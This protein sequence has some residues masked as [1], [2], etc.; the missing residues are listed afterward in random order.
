[1]EGDFN[2]RDLLCACGSLCLLRYPR[3]DE[4]G[5]YE[6]CF[7]TV[8]SLIVA[9]SLWA[10]ELY[11]AI[12]FRGATA[13]V[14]N[15]LESALDV[16]STAIVLYRLFGADALHHNARNSILEARIST[17]LCFVMIVLAG[18]FIGFAAKTFYDH[19]FESNQEVLTE[20]WITMPSVVAYLIVG[21]VQLQLSWTLK[22]TSL[23]QDAMISIFGALAA[24]G[25]LVSGL[26]SISHWQTAEL[27]ATEA[28]EEKRQIRDV[29]NST[30]GD[31]DSLIE[32]KWS[33]WWLDPLMTLCVGLLL[34]TYG[35]WLLYL[36]SKEFAWWKQAFWFDP[37]PPRPAP[38]LGKADVSVK[39]KRESSPLTA[40]A[41]ETSYSA[42]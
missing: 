3:F 23:K 24:F 26:V 13:I 17:F 5:R 30:G 18:V 8:V 11:M 21:V 22:L 40:S 38:P 14:E 1:M 35:L 37:L 16:F 2:D 39:G 12:R 33:S 4:P 41:P 42:S 10:V 19:E 6:A 31:A 27:T 36:D 9:L 29:V 34:M 28:E 15:C 7:I 32:Y 25:T 20:V